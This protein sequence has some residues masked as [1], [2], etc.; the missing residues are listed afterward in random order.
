MV[1]LSFYGINKENALFNHIR[2]SFVT[3]KFVAEN[4]LEGQKKRTGKGLRKG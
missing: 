3:E 2:E 1:E 4:H